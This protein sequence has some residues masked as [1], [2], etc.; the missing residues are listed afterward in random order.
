[1]NVRFHL[2]RHAR[3]AVERHVHEPPHIKGG[4]GG[5]RQTYTP[6]NIRSL[7]RAVGL[8]QDFILGEEARQAWNPGDGQR[9]HKHGPVRH[10]N[11]VFQ[12]AHVAHVL[13]PA[14]GVNH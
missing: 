7:R 13:L 4:H 12:P 2:R 9:R 1:M 5:G 3:L 10:G 11:L 6:Q 14:Q 8:P